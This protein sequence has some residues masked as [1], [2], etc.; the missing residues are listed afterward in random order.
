MRILLTGG[1]G[2]I[3]K[4]IRESWASLHEVSAPAHQELDLTDAEAVRAFFRGKAF[5]AVIH[6]AVRP[7]H[8]NAADPS[9]QIEINTRMFFNL[10]RN[11]ERFRKMVVLSSGLVY[12]QRN[13]RPKM[14]EDDFDTHVPLDDGGFSKYLIAKHIQFL[15][16]VVELRPFGVFGKYED[17]TIRFISNAI[18]RTL[19]D[20]PITLRR[21]RRFDYIWV[22]DLMPV[23]EFFIGHDAKHRS[24]NVTPD[25]PV[26][27][28]T[29]AQKVQKLSGKDLPILVGEAGMGVEYSGSNARLKEEM[30]ELKFT[31]TGEAVERLYEWYQTQ[32]SSIRK[33]DLL[34][35]R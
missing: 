11:Q 26:E 32:R 2:F 25:E 16:N 4:N 35:D 9:R 18:C 28:L 19:F 7:G 30:R 13:Y 34:V 14:R 1:S 31:P 3:G 8:R 10:I 33:E 15:D 20:L 6:T 24:Y 21:N 12:D 27:L 23:L 29:M 5:D 17:Y 22:N